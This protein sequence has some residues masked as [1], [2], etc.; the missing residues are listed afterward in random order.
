MSAALD[1]NYTYPFQSAL[2]ETAAEPRNLRLATFGGVEKNPYFFS[3]F[4]KNPKQCADLLLALSAISRTRFFSPG[5]LRARMVAAA[6]PV[7]TSDGT[8]LRFE[9][10]SVCCGAY[11]RLD[12]HGG[13][14]DGEWLNKGTTNVDFNPTM[15]A[16][17]G[18]VMNSEKVGLRVGADALELTRA[19]ETVVERK[20]KL[21]IRWLKGFVEVQVYQSSLKP[22][23]EIPALELAKAIRG[24]PQ[25]NILQAGTITYLV[26]AGQGVRLSQRDT[27]GAIAVGAI[28]RLKALEPILRYARTVRVYSGTDAVTAF[29]LVMPDACF[30]F[31]LSP[32]AARGFSGE[33]Q[34]LSGL[35]QESAPQLLAQV[36]SALAWQT[37]LSPEGL[38][39]KLNLDRESTETALQV[40]GTRGLV[41]YDLTTSSYFH[42]ELPFDLSLVEELHPRM[43][44]ARQL[45]EGGSIRISAQSAEDNYEAFVKGSK[46]DH[47][48]QVTPNGC[49]CTC[50]W[51]A[52][53]L[54]ARGPCSHILA[55][56]MVTQEKWNDSKRA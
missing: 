7:V 8:Q 42:R 13:G 4:L 9:V 44:K 43:K 24:L 31:V 34:A 55:A 3:G 54:G 37:N 25:Q 32:N 18:S 51:F 46:G 47:Y 14:I 29:E 40:L 56:E 1:F 38:S 33:G 39:T 11:S 26:P 16:A 19:G 12:I 28:S 23:L 45:V 49:R 48:V 10:F 52:K 5:E 30:I 27:A 50:D 21:P 36:R 22:C 41:G 20:V 2:L 53:N 35:S 17:L 15:R 6:D